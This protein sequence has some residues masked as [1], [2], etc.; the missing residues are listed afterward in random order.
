[1][2]A[3]HTGCGVTECLR[4]VSGT[5]FQHVQHAAHILETCATD[6]PAM[7]SCS[8]VRVE[9]GLGY[10]CSTRTRLRD[11]CSLEELLLGQK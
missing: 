6:R 7:P 2:S 3:N 10:L 8:R 4:V 5:S 1:M 9:H 11:M